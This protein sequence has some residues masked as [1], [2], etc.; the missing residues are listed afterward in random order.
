MGLFDNWYDY[1]NPLEYLKYGK[2][3][4]FDKP[5]DKVKGAYDQASTDAKAN[6]A[7]IRDMLMGQKQQA[8]G[9]YSPLQK[10]FS[11]AYGQNPGIAGP[12]TPGVPGS[13]PL[14]KMFGGGR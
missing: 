10:M 3:E 5:A 14:N 7:Q 6:S 9:F 8:L 2:Q 12:Q 11:N 13:M 1:V 4:L